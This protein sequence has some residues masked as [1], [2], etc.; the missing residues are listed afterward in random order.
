M[1]I[2]GVDINSSRQGFS[3]PEV[4]APSMSRLIGT[5]WALVAHEKLS[6]L[7]R[8]LGL[9]SPR[10]PLATLPLADR[11]D[12][13]AEV[14]RSLDPRNPEDPATLSRLVRDWRP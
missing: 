2:S 12:R 13:Y 1:E 11:I 7:D 3:C 5:T 10:S 4:L 8:G 9:F 14:G 6:G